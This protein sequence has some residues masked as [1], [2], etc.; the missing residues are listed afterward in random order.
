MSENEQDEVM[1][2]IRSWKRAV[3]E[4]HGGSMDAIADAMRERDRR[5][6]RTVDLSGDRPKPS[7]RG[8][9]PRESAA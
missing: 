8:A 3:S 1:A 7:D 9:G 5:E 6:D 4:E 2:E